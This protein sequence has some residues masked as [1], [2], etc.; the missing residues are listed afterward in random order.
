M[1]LGLAKLTAKQR[2]FPLGG[3]SMVLAEGREQLT[4]HLTFLDTV[5]EES[6]H[7]PLLICAVRRRDWQ[8]TV[9]GT[10]SVA[11]PVSAA[12]A[13]SCAVPGY[14]AGVKIRG[15]TYIDGGVVSATNADVLASYELDL[16][17]VVS[18]MT[19]ET[20]W[21]PVSKLVRQQCRRTLNQ[22]LRALQR[23][24]IPTVVIEPG[25][26]VLRHMSL[27]FMSEKANVEIV[28]NSFLDTGTQISASPLLRAL[29]A[30]AACRGGVGTI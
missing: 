7:E 2:G 15:E 16:A 13:A 17:I 26:S 3:L 12:V 30:R 14:F 18:P 8:R 6:S 23:R 9:F 11:A 20:R 10:D 19:G 27:D 21:P 5:T 28:Q 24:G 1:V 22:E 4:P 29:N 25:A